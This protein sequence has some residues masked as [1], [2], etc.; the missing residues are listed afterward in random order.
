MSILCLNDIQGIGAE[1]KQGNPFRGVAGLVFS[2]P[3]FS[4]ATS[5]SFADSDDWTTGIIGGQLFPV[6]GVKEDEDTTPDDTIWESSYG[7][8]IL[9]AEGKYSRTYQFNLTLDQH[10]KLR[11]YTGKKWKVFIIDRNNNVKCTV[12]ED[13]LYVGFDVSFMLIGK[14]LNPSADTPAN[15]PV[16]MEE[17]DPKQWND[18]GAYVTPSWLASQEILPLTEVT[19]TSSTVAADVFT[20]TV[21]F[22]AGLNADG[23]V[24]WIPI[25]GLLIT[26][27]III[28]QAGATLSN[29]GDYTATESATVAGQYEVDATVGSITSGSVQV[30]AT[31]A[32]LY[33][34]DVL[35]IVAA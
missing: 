32:A 14:M 11:E 6:M 24:K 16:M 18:N 8:K 33:R 35:A 4:F 17:A 19:I 20:I 23:S 15:T 9:I 1:C 7:D 31:A 27:L 25:S 3:D 34:S 22:N 13:G 30:V 12:N 29:A 26:N 10:Q 21:N 5:A 28:D 2:D